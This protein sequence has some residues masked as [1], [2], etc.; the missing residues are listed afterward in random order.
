[1]SSNDRS[2]PGPKQGQERKPA[3]VKCGACTTVCPVYQVTGRESL[4]ARGKHHLLAS[5]AAAERSAVFADIFSKC[6]LCGACQEVCAQD[7]KTVDRIVEARSAL[8]QLAGQSL[9]K[10]IAGKALE[11]PGLLPGLAATGRT[12]NK[13]LA[14]LLPEESGLRLRLAAFDLDIRPVANGYIKSAGTGKS[15]AVNYFVGCV[16]NHLLPEI[17]RAS[18]KLLSRL[19]GSAPAVPGQQTCCGLA[20]LA[21]G[22][23]DE[24]RELARKNIAAFAGS[25]LPVFTSC[26]S[27]YAQLMTYPELLAED[28]EWRGRAVEFAGRLLEFSTFAAAALEKQPALIRRAPAGRQRVLYHDPCHLRYRHKIISA[29]RRLLGLL[30]ELELAELPGG[31]RCCGQGGLFNLAHPELS[32]RIRGQLLADFAASGAELAVTSCS[33]C[34][35]QWRQGLAEQGLGGRVRH[36]AVLLAEYL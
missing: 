16:A 17:G 28:A 25:A 32:R 6:L 19:H 7:L 10:Y 11:H 9:L 30:P 20:A 29:P 24:A 15:P 23:I 31:P 2:G 4:T 22:N 36:L 14:G 33:G 3:C 1:M 18:E 13:A 35:L 21:A 34:L 8:P 5:L 27:C 26:A 12:L